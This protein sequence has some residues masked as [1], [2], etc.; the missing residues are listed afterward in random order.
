MAGFSTDLRRQHALTSL[1]SAATIQKTSFFFFVSFFLLPVAAS[2][3]G[4]ACTPRGGR[5]CRARR[6][7]RQPR[8]GSR[9]WWSTEAFRPPGTTAGR[10]RRCQSCWDS[11]R[12]LPRRPAG[13]A[14]PG[15]TWTPAALWGGTCC[16]PG[17][18]ADSLLW[19][20][21]AWCGLAS[22]AA[23]IQTLFLPSALRSVEDLRLSVISGTRNDRSLPRDLLW[24]VFPADK[25]HILLT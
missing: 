17:R 8:A 23:R 15:R 19:R 22:A 11:G 2:P 5:S 16:C 20:E 25:E 18:P 9:S 13:T 4:W 12:N 24:R 3:P 7:C 21:L 6:G 14:G 1:T 10:R